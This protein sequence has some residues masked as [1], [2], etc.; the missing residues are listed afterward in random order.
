MTKQANNLEKTFIAMNAFDVKNSSLS[1]GQQISHFEESLELFS[2]I[3]S[4]IK[5]IHKEMVKDFPELMEHVKEGYIRKGSKTENVFTVYKQLVKYY[6]VLYLG[7]S[8]SASE[9]LYQRLRKN[10]AF[11]GADFNMVSGW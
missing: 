7:L 2:V 5:T 11:S 9:L 4:P 8:N 6:G 10:K 3:D 1:V